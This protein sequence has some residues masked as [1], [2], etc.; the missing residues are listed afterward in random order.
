M[1]ERSDNRLHEVEIENI[2]CSF[3]NLE[4]M[5]LSVEFQVIKITQLLDKI[6]NLSDRASSSTKKL[7]NMKV[8]ICRQTSK[9]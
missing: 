2:S 3:N 6:T 5:K 9:S 8:I 4:A 7:S 1:T